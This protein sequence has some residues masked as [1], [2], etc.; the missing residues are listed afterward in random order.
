VPPDFSWVFHAHETYNDEREVS[1]ERIALSGQALL[2]AFERH[3]P[4]LLATVIAI[5]GAD[6]SGG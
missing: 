3:K 6:V 2:D 5:D 4:R 1:G